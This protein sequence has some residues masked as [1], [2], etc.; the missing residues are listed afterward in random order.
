MGLFLAP[1][2]PSICLMVTWGRLTGP[3]MTLGLLGGVAGGLSS[4]LVYTAYFD[5]GYKNFF[6]N[7]GR[8]TVLL[9]HS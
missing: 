7:S 1:P 9:R 8:P 6:D 4:W 2:V 3:A 5:T